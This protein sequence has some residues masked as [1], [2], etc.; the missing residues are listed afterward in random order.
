[1]TSMLDRLHA[2]HAN[3]TRLLT[4][5]E[6]Q[7]AMLEARRPTDVRL[8]ADIFQYIAHFPDLYHHPL[9]DF[10]F[11]L[12]RRRDPDSREVIDEIL[13]QHKELT[14]RTLALLNVLA[15]CSGS[16][17]F[18]RVGLVT[19]LRDYILLAH[20][21]MDI[22]ESRL[23]PQARAV[24]TA[25]DWQSIEQALCIEDDPLFGRVISRQY[26]WLYDAIMREST[27]QPP[28]RERG[29]RCPHPPC[30]GQ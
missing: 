7:A 14:N 15:A 23:F 13:G 16:A 21:H 11:E 25:Q 1:M 27:T 2:D 10:I 8:L 6:R 29:Y 4:L 9:E 26:R 17:I 20:Q 5:L 3:I 28:Q 24:L 30:T 18:S 19:Q 22:E 12:L